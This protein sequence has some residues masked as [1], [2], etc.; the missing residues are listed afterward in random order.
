M[1]QYS[2]SHAYI[3]A[4]SALTNTSIDELIRPSLRLAFPL[5]AQED[6]TEAKFEGLLAALARHQGA[7][8]G[9]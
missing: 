2:R 1:A 7:S 9:P 4:A 8:K 5:P 3:P 6:G